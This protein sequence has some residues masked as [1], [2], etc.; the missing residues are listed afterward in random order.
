MPLF[1][2]AH[3]PHDRPHRDEVAAALEL[4]ISVRDLRTSD[5]LAAEADRMGPDGEAAARFFRE[6][7]GRL[8]ARMAL[9]KYDS[10]SEEQ[11]YIAFEEI[12]VAM[13]GK[14]AALIP[15][16]PPYVCAAFL[17]L[18][19]S[20]IVQLDEH[21]APPQF[22][23]QRTMRHFADGYA[24]R[25]F[26]RKADALVFDGYS[27]GDFLVR[28]CVAD[29]LATIRPET[30]FFVHRRPHAHHADVTVPPDISARFIFI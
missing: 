26:A 13:G 1:G 2:R 18:E 19:G 22:H 23:Y 9:R 6:R 30:A 12:Q 3:P 20:A 5:E 15:P 14:T 24:A 25:Q 17:K 4:L 21:H 28:A 11:R 29:L 7:C 8:D 16:L 10:E 27:G